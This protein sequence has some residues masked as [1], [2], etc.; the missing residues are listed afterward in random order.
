MSSPIEKY[1]AKMVLLGSLR[2]TEVRADS[3]VDVLILA[4]DKLREVEEAAADCA[5]ETGLVTGESVEPLVYC[6]DELRYPTSYFYT[7]I[8]FMVRRS[9]QWMK[10]R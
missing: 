6:L 2:K 9:T 3:D 10:I 4:L 5:F 7:R 1:I 8:F